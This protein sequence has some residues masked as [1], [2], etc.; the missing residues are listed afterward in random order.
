MSLA[1]AMSR[2]G[3]KSD[4]IDQIDP[5]NQPTLPSKFDFVDKV[6]ARMR[7]R[8]GADWVRKFECV[9]HD[10]LKADWGQVLENLPSSAIEYGLENLPNRVPIATDFRSLCRESLRYDAPQLEITNPK[11]EPERWAEI[12]KQIQRVLTTPPDPKRP[13]RELKAKEDVGEYLSIHQKRYWREVLKDEILRQ[14]NQQVNPQA[15]AFACTDS[16]T[17]ASNV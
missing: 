4:A 17:G 1:S 14:E 16:N 12:K 10:E 15:V 7:V 6:F 11:I 5:H 13:A 9:S 3:R 2:L 8:Y